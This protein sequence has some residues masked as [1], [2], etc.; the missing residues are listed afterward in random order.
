MPVNEYT[1]ICLILI[2]RC[3][4]EIV[5]LGTFDKLLNRIWIEGAIETTS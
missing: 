3:V 4:F 5:L 1:G 2:D